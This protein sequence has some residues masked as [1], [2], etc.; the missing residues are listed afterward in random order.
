MSGPLHVAAA[1]CAVLIGAWVLQRSKGTWLHVRA[2][3]V[4]GASMLLVNVAALATSDQTGRLGAFH[5]LAM[6]SL[7]TVGAGWGSMLFSRSRAVSDLARHAYFMTWSYIGLTA[8]GIAQL[9]SLAWPQWEPWP[10][11]VSS[12]LVISVGGGLAHRRLPDVL[13]RQQNSMG[14]GGR[15]APD[16]AL[17]G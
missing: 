5:I 8:A 16:E 9:A 15:R 10:V 11:I 4:Y 13:E 2:G 3:R 12:G 1:V 17:C 14:S 7:L 6:V